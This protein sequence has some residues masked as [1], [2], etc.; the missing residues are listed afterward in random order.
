MP[1]SIYDGIMN[2]PTESNFAVYRADSVK[3]AVREGMCGVPFGDCLPVLEEQLAKVRPGK[4]ALCREWMEKLKKIKSEEAEM[5]FADFRTQAGNLVDEDGDAE[6][7]VPVWDDV[8]KRLHD[9][10][11]TYKEPK[12]AVIDSETIEKQGR[13]AL[14]E[15][16]DTV[17]PTIHL[18]NKQNQDEFKDAVYQKVAEK[19][20]EGTIYIPGLPKGGLDPNDDYLGS[21]IEDM[22]SY[23]PKQNYR[24]PDSVARAENAEEYDREAVRN[25]FA[26]GKKLEQMI[27]DEARINEKH[28]L[29]KAT[30]DEKAEEQLKR[31]DRRTLVNYFTLNKNDI[32][33]LDQTGDDKFKQVL[34]DM[35][36][37]FLTSE[38]TR[39]SSDGIPMTVTKL[40]TVVYK[41]GGTNKTIR[42][43]GGFLHYRVR[44]PVCRQS[45]NDAVS[46]IADL[47]NV[48]HPHT[49][50]SF[51]AESMAEDIAVMYDRRQLGTLF[52]A[53]MLHSS[54][55]PR[56]KRDEEKKQAEDRKEF[57]KSVE[58]GF[59]K[60]VSGKSDIVPLLEFP[61]TLDE[62]KQC[63]KQG[64]GIGS[65]LT[66]I[67]GLDSR[68][69]KYTRPAELRESMAKAA[70]RVSEEEYA[71]FIRTQKAARAAYAETNA[72]YKREKQD[73]V[74]SY[75]TTYKGIDTPD[76]YAATYFSGDEQA[77]SKSTV[78]YR[79]RT[80]GEPWP[81]EKYGPE[82][83]SWKEKL[84]V[85][86]RYNKEHPDASFE[87]KE[88]QGYL[89]LESGIA[90]PQSSYS[91]NFK[92]RLKDCAA[93]KKSK[94]IWNQSAQKD[95]VL[96][97]L[98]R[99]V[100][101]ENARNKTSRPP[102]PVPNESGR[103]LMDAF[104]KKAE[105]LMR[106]ND[107]T[108]RQAVSSTKRGFFSKLF[109]LYKSPS[110][111]SLSEKLDTVLKD[112]NKMT[113]QTLASMK[114]DAAMLKNSIERMPYDKR[115]KE[116][117]LNR[118][119][120]AEAILT[121]C[122]AHK[123]RVDL[124][125]KELAAS[126]RMNKRLYDTASRYWE[127]SRSTEQVKENQIRRDK[128][129]GNPE[130]EKINSLLSF[131]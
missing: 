68:I 31:E 17:A 18:T 88:Y 72:Q 85:V 116:L 44:K 25:R 62:L 32:T 74:D 96:I 41:E 99:Q 121:T 129:K 119:K 51:L 21:L 27:Q 36:L 131:A 102:E 105:E 89:E 109:G 20:Y 70:D 59:Q 49:V 130:M 11:R 42:K 82:P 92:A 81:E 39:V 34:K 40:P 118:L 10:Q 94:E 84:D 87:D 47:L 63:L 71:A 100:R 128:L 57:F 53:D 104:V 79:Y 5:S 124:S 22:E 115:R 98:A 120:L 106:E 80:A 103:V 7:G 60:L 15:Y 12:E 30:V 111:D 126:G 54:Y 52:K 45:I 13:Y 38:D 110:Y 6:T 56:T 83:K 19:I 125:Q 65:D 114:N 69:G 58:E 95:K 64:D 50:G 78:L 123:S 43:D 76:Y 122:E 35:T 112:P 93:W 73:F 77:K 117:N 4:Q 108:L 46:Y 61:E 26:A 107:Q 91:A 55:N 75:S 3:I 90:D 28:D 48:D 37:A 86:T 1:G 97:E 8:L 113:Y 67:L 16:L 9:C 23:L 127:N 101:T 29:Q 24:L 2:F 14:E 33:V 66:Y